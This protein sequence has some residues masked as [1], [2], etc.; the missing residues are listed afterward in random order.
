VDSRP[1]WSHTSVAAALITLGGCATIQPKAGFPAVQK[2]VAD[3]IDR[4][5]H[6]DQG[7]PDDARVKEAVTQ[8]LASEL[9]VDGAVQVALLNNPTLQATYEDLGVAQADVVEAGL[10]KNPVFSGFARIPHTP[11]SQT[12]LE[13]D[14][15]EEFITILFLPARKRIAS[16]NF[17]A[18]KL[19]VT[20]AVLELAARVRVAYYG[21]AAA[22]N[23]ADA[24]RRNAEA[25]RA[26]AELAGKIYD[27]GNL[28]DL[29]LAR[30]RALATQL[31]LE[32][33]KSKGEIVVARE[34]LTRLMG[35]T[36]DEGAWNVPKQ[37][38]AIPTDEPSLADLE[39][40]AL[41]TRP[42]LAAGREE[43]DALRQGLGLTRLTRWFPFVELGIDNERE[44]DGQWVNGPIVSLQ[45]PVFNQ[46]QADVARAEA[47]LRRSEKQLVSLGVAARSEIRE[48]RE[49]M[50]LARRVVEA[51]RGTL[52]P[53]R[54]EVLSR[55]LEHYN[56]MF[57]GAFDVLAAKR[58]E[59]EAYRAYVT[60][61]RDYWVAR[62]DLE[63]ALGRRL[64][65]AFNASELAEPSAP[66]EPTSPPAAPGEHRGHQ[67]GG[68]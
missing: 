65:V 30:E 50:L 64:A 10:F 45:I 34:A 3:R 15:A 38:P 16:T 17:E 58:D 13:F 2:L 63:R 46:G 12:N 6:W 32:F 42:D 11:P 25:A 49:R 4:E 57:I 56:Y 67:H 52:I 40:A 62:S 26:S 9:N 39:R 22:E 20:N 29:D 60:S 28:S 24:L 14:V 53:L 31:A 59:I 33:E 1:K 66:P 37:L 35:L 43:V 21:L 23:L 48:S 47:E 5:V 18:R 41:T 19:H 55:A 61:V 44:T 7:T 68:H 51:Y 8:L 27:A 54:Q 36:G